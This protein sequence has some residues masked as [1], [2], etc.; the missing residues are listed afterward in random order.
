MN[1]DI[2]NHIH[3]TEPTPP[4]VNVSV[5]RNSRGCNWSA[6][7]TGAGSVAE[8]VAMLGEAVAAMRAEYGGGACDQPVTGLCREP[9]KMN[10]KG[11]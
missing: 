4:K 9:A 8:A 1:P 7:V 6:T 3:R 5:E 10:G 11:A 2:V